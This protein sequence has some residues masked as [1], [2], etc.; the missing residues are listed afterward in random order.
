MSVAGDVALMADEEAQVEKAQET[1]RGP[2]ELS[3]A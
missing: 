3:K 2:C 1:M